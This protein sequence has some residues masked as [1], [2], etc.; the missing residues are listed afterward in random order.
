ML[1]KRLRQLEA[2]SDAQVLALVS[3]AI[4][5]SCVLSSQADDSTNARSF[6]DIITAKFVFRHPNDQA[7]TLLYTS[8]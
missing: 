5:Q 7:Q 6:F 4:S 1:M 8:V 3:G 2:G